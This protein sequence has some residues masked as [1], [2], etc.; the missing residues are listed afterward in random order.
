MKHK[1]LVV[2]RGESQLFLSYSWIGY[3]KKV[4]EVAE[5]AYIYFYI[6]IH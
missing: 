2:L 4:M 1:L 6:I 5:A 3:Q